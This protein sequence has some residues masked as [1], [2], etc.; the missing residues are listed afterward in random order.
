MTATALGQAPGPHETTRSFCDRELRWLALAVAAFVAFVALLPFLR[1]VLEAITR[2]GSLDLSGAL[3]ALSHPHVWQASLNT[4]EIGLAS[5]VI[6]LTLGATFAIT[7]AI[8]DVP[9]KRVLV[10]VFIWSLM[11]APQVAA[12]AFKTLLGPASPLLGA[13]G[14]APP[15]GTPN[16]VVGKL[17]II[18]VLGLH[19]APL[20]AITLAPAL[21]RI[22]ASVIDAARVDG[23]GPASV[24][25]RIIVPLAA[26][27]LVAASL[28]VLLAG[29][30]NFGIPALLGIPAGVLTLPTLIYR[31]LS[32]FGPSVIADT[33]TLSLMTGS[34]A[35]VVALAATAAIGRVRTHVSS[36]ATMQPFLELG[37]AR[38]PIAVALW[39]LIA[40]SAIIP[41]LSLV[42]TSLVPAYGMRLGFA[43]LTFE[44]YQEVLARQ[45]L[46]Y[47]ALR[48]S[49]LLAGAAAVLLA[50]AAVFV[51]YVIER[52]PRRWMPLL[53]TTLE[54]P[55]VLPG[56]VLAIACI[57]LFLKPLPLIGISIYATP[58]IILFAYL[59]RFLPVALKPVRATLANLARDCEEAAAVDGAR[60]WQRLVRVVGP[61]VLPSVLAGG[62]LVFLLAFNELTVSALLWSAGTE[63]LGVALLSLEDAGLATEAAALAVVT[64]LIVAGLLIILDRLSRVLPRGTLPWDTLGR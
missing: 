29:I 21:A 20:A 35:I 17:G 22:P 33:A 44:A 37:R 13:I 36:D 61:S 40:V 19:H 18:A 58:A 16:P 27:A 43:T 55:Y 52:R 41:F 23:A 42:A 24:V 49:G 31:Q 48:N 63:T 57:L 9:A 54:L 10:L 64:A 5:S 60:L 26:P 7:L 8:A 62:L 2:G 28:I 53:E 50:F 51:A 59:A 15:A 4:L 14:L 46:T 38:G 30:G 11:I 25:L 45:K 39:L 1:L 6:A 12:L 3:R 32:S 34:L 47:R 56:V